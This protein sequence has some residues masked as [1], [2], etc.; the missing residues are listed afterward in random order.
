M[1]CAR[2]YFFDQCKMVLWRSWF[3]IFFFTNKLKGMDRRV[4]ATCVAQRTRLAG[5]SENGMWMELFQMF[6]SWFQY[7]LFSISILDDN[8]QDSKRLQRSF[9]RGLSWKSNDMA[10]NGTAMPGRWRSR[11]APDQGGEGEMT[12]AQAQASNS[13]Q[14]CPRTICPISAQV[15]L[16]HT[17]GYISEHLHQ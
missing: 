12:H 2:I 7:F 6:V 9:W 15:R 17:M 1:P 8:L 11:L 10:T 3:T 14:L 4:E 16:E 5:D 13:M